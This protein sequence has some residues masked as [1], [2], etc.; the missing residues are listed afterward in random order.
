MSLSVAAKLAH[1]ELASVPAEAHTGDCAGLLFSRFDS[2]LTV[3]KA[4]GGALVG[5]QVGA[6]G[7]VDS[8]SQEGAERVWQGVGEGGM[9]RRYAA[10][11]AAGVDPSTPT[12]SWSRAGWRRAAASTSTTIF[13]C[14]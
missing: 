11:L 12:S 14:S 5:L 2:K 9:H 3:P 6:D 4:A 1:D 8:G 7:Q 13:K 10:K